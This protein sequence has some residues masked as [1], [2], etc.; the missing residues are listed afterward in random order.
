MFWRKKV[1]MGTDE[2]TDP[3]FGR[4]L[5]IIREIRHTVSIVEV[6]KINTLWVINS[7]ADLS[8]P[9][10]KRLWYLVRMEGVEWPIITDLK[11][12]YHCKEAIAAYDL[13]KIIV[14]NLEGKISEFLKNAVVELINKWRDKFI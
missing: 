5:A 7:N 2:S 8:N 12:F 1:N 11:W 10:K 6:V 3:P 13:P 14:V 9:N 4:P